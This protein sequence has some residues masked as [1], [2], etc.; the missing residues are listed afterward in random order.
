MRPTNLQITAVLA[1]LYAW[2]GSGVLTREDVEEAIRTL[3]NGAQLPRQDRENVVRIALAWLRPAGD[4]GFL[5]T[6]AALALI[7]FAVDPELALT[8]EE[9]EQFLELLR[10]RSHDGTLDSQELTAVTRRFLEDVLAGAD[11]PDELLETIVTTYVRRGTLVMSEDG[12]RYTVS[13]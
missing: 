9:D 8:P 12:G 7:G 1:V 3:P 5:L 10:S 2:H 11:I 4:R 13:V 6:D